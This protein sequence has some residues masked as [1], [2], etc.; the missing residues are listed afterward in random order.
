MHWQ[1]AGCKRSRASTAELS[2]G[3]PAGAAV[4]LFFSALPRAPPAAAAAAPLQVDRVRTENPEEGSQPDELF[5][6]DIS[7]P[8]GPT[9]HRWVLT[10]A[11]SACVCLT[12][13]LRLQS[14]LVL[15]CL[16]SASVA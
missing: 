14:W 4:L 1:A 8:Y 3:R 7:H 16:L 6:F 15:L 2:L 10:P 12:A 5:L 13:Q 11:G 9:G